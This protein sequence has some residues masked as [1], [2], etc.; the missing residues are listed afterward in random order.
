M[1]G[2]LVVLVLVGCGFMVALSASFDLQADPFLPTMVQLI[3]V[4]LS[5][6]TQ[7]LATDLCNV[8]RNMA[9][10]AALALRIRGLNA[11]LN[12]KRHPQRNCFII[13]P[14]APPGPLGLKPPRLALSGGSVKRSSDLI[15][16]AICNKCATHV[17]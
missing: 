13:G 7:A 16:V 8:Q 3:V 9:A 2:S 5:H 4:E 12:P 11:L 1:T 10:E 15:F 17:V 6:D 14:G